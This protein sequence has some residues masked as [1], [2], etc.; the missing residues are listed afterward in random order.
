MKNVEKI[1][2]LTEYQ[3]EDRI[4][5]SHVFAK[6]WEEAEKLSEQKGEKVYGF[7][8]PDCTDCEKQVGNAFK[9]D[10]AG[11]PDEYKRII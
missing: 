10:I 3:K 2:Y 1:K 5:A 6:S 11:L 7:I 4:Y 9:K 8:P